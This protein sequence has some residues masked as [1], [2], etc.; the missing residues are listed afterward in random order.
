MGSRYITTLFTFHYQEIL[1]AINFAK[2]VVANNEQIFVG[3]VAATLLAK[4]YIKTPGI[5]PHC[6]LLTSSRQIGF[7]DDVNIDLV[8]SD[9]SILTQGYG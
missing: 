1:E 2:K 9:Y 3:G 4:K 6:G 8:T 5:K 7:S